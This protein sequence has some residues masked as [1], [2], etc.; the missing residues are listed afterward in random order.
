MTISY[1]TVGKNA[2]KITT[3]VQEPGMFNYIQGQDIPT[4]ESLILGTLF[5]NPTGVRCSE[6][7]QYNR[8]TSSVNIYLKEIRETGFTV[9]IRK[10]GEK[11]RYFNPKYTG[12]VGFTWESGG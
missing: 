8:R 1:H 7:N 2:Q 12:S 3:H 4:D 6:R 11:S 9:K 10:P 5:F